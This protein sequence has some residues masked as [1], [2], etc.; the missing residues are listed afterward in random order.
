MEKSVALDFRTAAAE[1]VDVVAFHSDQ[2]IGPVQVDAPV[3][4][5]I[6]GGRVT[7][8]S[9]EVVV[10]DGHPVRS[11][12]AEDQMLAADPCGLPRIRA[13]QLILDS[14]N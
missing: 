11:A 2:I 6:T 7:S 13:S 10:G 4:V 9:I 1:M 8:H 3:V 14:G 5:A 12:G